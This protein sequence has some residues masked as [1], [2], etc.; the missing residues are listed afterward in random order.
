MAL[1]PTSTF[2]AH[3]V[4]SLSTRVLVT[5]FQQ[6]VVVQLQRAQT[7]SIHAKIIYLE[8]TSSML[9]TLP[10]HVTLSY[11]M[12]IVG[13]TLGLGVTALVLNLCLGHESPWLIP[14]L[15]HADI[16]HTLALEYSR[17]SHFRSTLSH[18]DRFPIDFPP[19][20]GLLSSSK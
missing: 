12:R 17:R 1:R 6:R 10:E 4:S 2:F 9:S 7:Q 13:S 14:R 19:T 18:S 3:N 5:W 20:Y 11:L 15:L 16:E 8:A